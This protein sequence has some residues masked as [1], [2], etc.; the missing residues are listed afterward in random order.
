MDTGALFT[1]W[2]P[3]VF[4]SNFGWLCRAER[5]GRV[6]ISTGYTSG[7]RRPSSQALTLPRGV[8]AWCLRRPEKGNA[9]GPVAFLELPDASGFWPCDRTHQRTA[10]CHIRTLMG[11]MSNIDRYRS[12]SRNRIALK[13]H[14]QQK[15]NFGRN[16][17]SWRLIVFVGL[18]HL[19]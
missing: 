8:I 7:L 9:D 10:L 11:R 4:G 5:F 15:T 6:W 16:T 13:D 18:S 19:S 3:P 1:A 2:L 14:D 17:S 12:R